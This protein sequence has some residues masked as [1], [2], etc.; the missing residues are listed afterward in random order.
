MTA[1]TNAPVSAASSNKAITSLINKVKK[2]GDEFNETVHN[3]MVAIAIH[4]QDYGDCTA[5]A[6]LVDAMPNTSRK[7]L[8]IKH[9]GEYSPIRVVKSTKKGDNGSMKASLRRDGD[10]GYNDFNIEGLKANPWY[11]RED[12]KRDPEFDLF[13][14]SAENK[15]WA[16]VTQLE[17]MATAKVTIKNAEGKDVQVN[18]INEH[19]QHRVKFL[20][21]SIKSAIRAAKNADLSQQQ[22]TSNDTNQSDGSNQPMTNAA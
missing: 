8:V 1:N 4:A 13:F 19:D 10:E 3:A 20:A 14:T 15:A 2:S 9:F 18:K 6:R 17:N 16:L 5:A 7:T 21:A 22:D 11:A 12:A